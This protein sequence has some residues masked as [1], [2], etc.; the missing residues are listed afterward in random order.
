[1]LWEN[2]ECVLVDPGF[3]GEQL[4]E[5]VRCKNKKVAAILLTHGH[6]DHVGAVRYIA[7]ETGCPVYIHAEDVTLPSRHTNGEIFHTHTYDEGDQLTFGGMTLTCIGPRQIA[8]K[9]EA[10][11]DSLNFVLEYGTR[12]FLFTGDFAQSGCINNEYRELCAN[13]D[14]LKFPHHG[15][16]PYEVGNKAM[17]VL[18]PQYILV[19]GV[20]YQYKL[21]NDYDNIG[22][23]FPKEN[24]FTNA[25]GHV[26]ILTDGGERFDV[27]IQQKPE[28]YAPKIN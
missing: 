15:H 19:P 6:F 3:E 22:V 17:K 14:V 23:K 9:G 5:R 13:V 8:R 4:L 20:A 21:W 28:D 16:E 1:M 26:V 11:V 24:I 7:E 10:N 12:K 18:R 25:E 27:L 2:E